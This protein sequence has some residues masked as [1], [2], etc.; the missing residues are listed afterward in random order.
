MRIAWMVGLMFAM[1]ILSTLLVGP[2]Y[3]VE[4]NCVTLQ[5]CG[6]T[7]MATMRDILQAVRHCVPEWSARLS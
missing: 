6:K 5:A 2:G 4:A 3:G 1:M 7:L